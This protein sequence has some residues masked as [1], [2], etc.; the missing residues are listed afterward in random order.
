MTCYQI[1]SNAAD[2]EKR[3]SWLIQMTMIFEACEQW[4]TSL[5]RITVIF[6]AC[7]QRM[8][9]LIQITDFRGSVNSAAYS[10]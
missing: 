8:T 3:M 4:M 7:E 10:P 9:L 2:G 5:I 6:E 1:W